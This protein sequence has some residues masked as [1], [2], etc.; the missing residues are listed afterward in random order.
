MKNNNT[1]NGINRAR[2]DAKDEYYTLME[3][4]EEEMA[5]Y[6][7][8]FRGLTVLCNCDSE[9]SNFWKY[10]LK[11]FNRLGLKKIMAVHKDVYFNPSYALSSTDGVEVIK[12]DLIGNGDFRD[13]ES[14]TF[15]EEADVVVTNPPFSL[16]REHFQ[17][18]IDYE[19]KFIVL[20]NLMAACYHD[21]FPLIKEGRVWIGHR[22]ACKKMYFEL[23]EESKAFMLNSRTMGSNY[24][25]IDGKM[26]GMVSPICWFTNFGEPYYN[27]PIPLTKSIQDGGYEFFDNYPA[28]NVDSVENIPVDF[29]GI[30]GVPVTFIGKYNPSQFKLIGHEGDVEGN[31]GAGVPEGQFEVDGK[32]KFRRVLIQR[33]TV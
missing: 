4:I 15:L 13:Y 6:E 24:K 11:N 33:A 10:F 5:H 3:D 2:K 21:I 18:L 25:I 12:T 28:L 7:E 19:K 17:Q 30:M 14:C 1:N 8:Y 16:F 32:L 26:Y 20:G 27:P 9:E 22:D 23:P 29:D 31:Y